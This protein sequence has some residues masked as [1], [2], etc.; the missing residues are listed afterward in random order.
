MKIIYNSW[1]RIKGMTHREAYMNISFEKEA[2][3]KWNANLGE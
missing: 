2:Y 1:Y 3:V